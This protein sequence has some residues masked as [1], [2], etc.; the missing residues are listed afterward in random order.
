LKLTPNELDRFIFKEKAIA[1]FGTIALFSLAGTAAREFWF[2]K[3]K[4]ADKL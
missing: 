2:R 1:P 4:S 3:R